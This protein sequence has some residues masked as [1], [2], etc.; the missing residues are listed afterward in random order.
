MRRIRQVLHLHFGAG[1]SAR[2]I[3]GEVG[4]GRTTVQDYLARVRG[5]EFSPPE[6]G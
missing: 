5:P 6:A 3:A 1:A 4:V 2:V